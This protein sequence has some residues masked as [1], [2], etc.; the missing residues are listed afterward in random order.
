VGKFN[1]QGKQSPFMNG[2]DYLNVLT[3]HIDIS[4]AAFSDR[5]SR[6]LVF[7]NPHQNSLFV[8]LAERLIQLDADVEAY[9]RRPPFIQNLC[10]IDQDGSILDFEVTTHPHCL[11][12][13]TRLGEINL[14]FQNERTLSFGLPANLSAGLRFRVFP[15]YWSTTPWGGRIISV[16]NVVFATTGQALHNQITPVE[17][18]YEVEFIVKADD[19]CAITIGIHP[20]APLARTPKPFSEALMDAETRWRNWFDRVP[21]VQEKYARMYAYAWWVMAS[22]LISPQGAVLYEA[23]TPSK[24]GYIGLWLW[25][26]AMHALAYRHVDAEL[27]RNQ[28]R[29]MLTYQLNNGMLPDAVFDEG[30][31][32]TIDHPITGEVTKPPILAWAAL[33]LHE[34]DP[35]IDFLQEIYV[36]L[37][38]VN[39]W[40][41]SM[42]DDD[43]DGLAQYNHPYSSGLD[44]SPLWDEGMPVE[45]PDLNTYLCVQMG[46]LAM[47]AE[48]L[49]MEAEAA[50][51]RRRTSAMVKRMIEHFWDAEAGLFWAMRDHKPVHVVTPFNLYPLWT[52]QLPREIIDRLLEHLQNPDEFWGNYLLPT[53]AR[54]DPK[55]DPVTMWRGPVWAN[56]NY[57]F[58][59][60]LQQIGEMEK[61]EELR[62]RTLD[63]INAHGDIYE[64]YNAETGEPSPKAVNMF[65][66]TSAVFIDLA[67]QA[68]QN[69]LE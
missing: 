68:N 63:M 60:A 12:L 61:A 32:S 49:N 21:P 9:L 4:K 5:G 18:G 34:T 39:A 46:S 56:I 13:M 55:Y 19:D 58:V 65:G 40:W 29:A 11:Q 38:R 64:Y 37:V 54:N 15:Q 33:K 66:W 10:L 59:E 62:I 14:V 1:L 8:R 53:V 35:N 41:L 3:N 48:A 44:D 23:M 30:I 52:G 67:I 42:N 28:I 31:V 17:G 27:A 57:F 20:D 7:R 26:N 25:D 51:W 43:G 50:M 22:N 6:L 2:V 16:R 24:L 45:S 47:I 69:Q 36:P